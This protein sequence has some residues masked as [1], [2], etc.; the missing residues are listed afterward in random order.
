MA[1]RTPLDR[2]IPRIIESLGYDPRPEPR[3]NAERLIWKR[4]ALGLARKT[5]ARLIGGR[6]RKLGSVGAGGS[7]SRPEP[8]WTRCFGSLMAVLTQVRSALGHHQLRIRGLP[9]SI[10]RRLPQAGRQ[11]VMR[12]RLKICCPQGRGSSSPPG[13]PSMCRRQSVAEANLLRLGVAG[14]ASTR[15]EHGRNELRASAEMFSRSLDKSRASRH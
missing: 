9:R 14:R 2:Y 8:G 10:R 3:T 11:N 5:T 1:G 7:D 4:Q 13:A 6:R 15:R 12:G